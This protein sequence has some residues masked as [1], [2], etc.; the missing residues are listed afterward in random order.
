MMAQQAQQAGN[1]GLQA[2]QTFAVQTID[3]ALP[4][5]IS[6]LQQGY[7][8]QR[9]DLEQARGHFQPFYDQ[10]TKA[11]Q[12]AGDATGVNGAD[13]YA[14]AQGSFQATPGYQW[15]VDQNMKAVTGQQAALGELLSGNTLAALQN[16]GN[17][18]ANQEYG[19]WYDRVAGQAGVGYNAAERMADIG[20]RLG[21]AAG[22]Y[23]QN[24]SG[25][26]GQ[27]ALAKAGIYGDTAA[28]QADLLAKM[29][30]AQID[31]SQRGAEAGEKASTN[32]LTLGIGLANTLATLGS[33]AMGGGGGVGAK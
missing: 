13:G 26:Y 25:V 16:R 33:R 31:A 29:T 9:A 22:Q 20:A 15:N 6:A 2:G 12:L 7:D 32:R 28:K 17:Q 5:Q 14:R 4:S 19:S 8:T 3:G 30:G 18:L 23:G 21:A 11:W 10:G 1:A 24:V 27:G